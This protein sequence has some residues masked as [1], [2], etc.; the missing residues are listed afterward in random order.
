MKY[1]CLVYQDEEKLRGLPDGALD[2]MIVE[3][4]VWVAELE[5]GGHHVFSACLQS[6]RSAATVR[7]WTGQIS[8]TDGPFAETKEFLGGF[9][10]LEA[11]DLNQAIHLASKLPAVRIGSIE[12]RPVLDADAEVCDPLDRKVAAALRRANH[13]ISIQED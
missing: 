10:I 12:V 2:E 1:I 7:N 8:V 5:A 4:G 13:S 9:T 11:R 3:C 6:I